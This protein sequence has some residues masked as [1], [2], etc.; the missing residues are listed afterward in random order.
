MKFPDLGALVNQVIAWA[1]GVQRRHGVFG[2][3]YAVIR[4]YGDDD[5]GREAALITYYGFLS[6]FPLLLLGVAILSKVLASDPGLRQQLITAIVPP[7]LQPTVKQA[8]ASLPTSTV[9][10]IAGLIGLLFSGTGVVFSAYQTLNNVAAVP[11]RLRAGFIPRYIRVFVMLA[12]LLLGAVAVGTLTVV[13]TALPDVLGVERAVAVAGSALIIFGVLMLGS[14]LL[15]V[16]HAPFRAL[17]PGAVMGAVTVTLVLN[18]GPPL[19]ARLVA[20]AGPVYGSFATVAGMFALLYLV[21]QA[22]VYS[23]EV[24][25][26]RYARLWPRAVDVNN[27]TAADVRAMALLA[28]EQERIQAARVDLR[29]VSRDL[30]PAAGPGA[31]PGGVTRP[32]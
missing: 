30:P 23:A 27:P 14:R 8:E 22:L 5:G 28:G 25:A 31:G 10:F 24:A 3:P 12:T 29:L 6:I 16:R 26:V 2:F 19:L 9:P 15:L 21:S 20:K 17:W 32:G 13:A 18:L 7:R 1:D 11:R 4:K